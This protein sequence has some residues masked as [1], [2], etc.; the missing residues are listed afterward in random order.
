MRV[1]LYMT[2]HTRVTKLASCAVV[3]RPVREIRE[4]IVVHETGGSLMGNFFR[5]I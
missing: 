5:I 3:H 4:S 2:K 1:T